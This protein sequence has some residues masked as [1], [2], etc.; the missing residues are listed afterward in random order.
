MAAGRWSKFCIVVGVTLTLLIPLSLV[1]DA[2]PAAKGSETN[3]STPI[4]AEKD[5][6]L[7]ENGV[8]EAS[9]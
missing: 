7:L 1:M 2:A 4:A 5:G 3:Q 6:N 8:R 9:S